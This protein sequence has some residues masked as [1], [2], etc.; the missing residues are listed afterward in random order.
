M[1]PVVF[2]V[3][4]LGI[5]APTSYL[6]SFF[7]SLPIKPS[8]HKV[9]HVQAVATASLAMGPCLAKPNHVDL[10]Q[11]SPDTRLSQRS[12]QVQRGGCH[13]S[14]AFPKLSMAQGHLAETKLRQAQE[15]LG[16]MV[17][18]PAAFGSWCLWLIL[19]STKRAAQPCLSGSSASPLDLG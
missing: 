11:V 5:A 2:K 18:T 19:W 7:T 14:V 15:T 1:L 10:Q 13:S 9:L 3:L 12:L 17:W 16:S 4:P 8:D 6:Q